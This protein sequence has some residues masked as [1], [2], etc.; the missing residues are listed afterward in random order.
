[1]KTFFLMCETLCPTV[2]AYE[3]AL[4]LFAK[5]THIGNLRKA[6][7]IPFYYYY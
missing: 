1:M 3:Q 4:E 5:N 2:E 7:R 6:E